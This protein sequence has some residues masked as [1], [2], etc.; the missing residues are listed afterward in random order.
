M[1][2]L[3]WQDRKR[4]LEQLAKDTITKFGE[5][6]Y[7]VFIFGSFVR[8][9]Y[10]PD[11]SDLDLA[12]YADDYWNGVS[13]AAYLERYLAA[14]GVPADILMFDT[15]DFDSYVFIDPLCTNITFT[16]YHPKEL[17]NYHMTLSCKYAR[18]LEEMKYIDSVAECVRESYKEL[19]L[20]K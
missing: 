16:D 19:G 4:F 1:K 9:D 11:T 12:V 13:I 7:N 8:D 6:G 5:T 14:L 20:V 2:F 10:N 3:T 15:E 18:H 17:T